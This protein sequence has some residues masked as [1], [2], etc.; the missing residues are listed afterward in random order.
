[1]I[2]TLKFVA[3]SNINLILLLSTDS[4]G[5]S[6]TGSNI[7]G[8]EAMWFQLSP[9]ELDHHMSTVERQKELTKFLS[10]Y[11]S[12]GHTLFEAAHWFPHAFAEP[13]AHSLPTLFGSP[14]DRR[15]LAG[16]CLFCGKNVEEGY[17]IVYRYEVNSIFKTPNFL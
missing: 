8:S 13:L 6:S 5:S 15:L 3:Y 14:S 16:L 2:Q 10:V 4:S 12:E 9:K 1:M 11:E 17:G 7:E